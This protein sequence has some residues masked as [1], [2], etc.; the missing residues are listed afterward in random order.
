MLL[1]IERKTW[2]GYDSW[3]DWQ[4]FTSIEI[5]IAMRKE[6]PFERIFW[7]QL[8]QFFIMHTKYE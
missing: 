4:R 2:N 8:F 7:K 6:T 1:K 3:I 5:T